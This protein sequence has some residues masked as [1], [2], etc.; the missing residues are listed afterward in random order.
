MDTDEGVYLQVKVVL[1]FKEH[2]KFNIYT[3][4]TSFQ[5]GAAASS[6]PDLC[7][8]TGR[9]CLESEEDEPAYNGYG[10]S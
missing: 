8:K 5:E 6:S 9:T 3:L 10:R 2:V 4:P 7:D 1:I